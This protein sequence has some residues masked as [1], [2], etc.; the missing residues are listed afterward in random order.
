MKHSLSLILFLASISAAPIFAASVQVVAESLRMTETLVPVKYGSGDLVDISIEIS[1]REEMQQSDY[2][3][4]ILLRSDLRKWLDTYNM[5]PIEGEPAVFWETVVKDLSIRVI[6][7]YPTINTAALSF[8]VYPNA[9][10]P[11][12]HTVTSVAMRP[13]DAEDPITVK[14]SITLPISMYAIEHQGPQV[15]D[16]STKL[17]YNENLGIREYPASEE[18]YAMLFKLMEDYPVESDYW[19][20]L[21][22]S[23]SADILEAFPQLS[24]IEMDMRVYPTS[25]VDYFHDVY[26]RTIRSKNETE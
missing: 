21:V 15:I 25:T 24:A 23:M 18:I 17:D 6:E 22:K 12:P 3:D 9:H 4:F 16:L 13:E 26:C 14:E 2:P 7:N 5:V 8:E 11:Y 1:Y 20:T 10:Y 19:E